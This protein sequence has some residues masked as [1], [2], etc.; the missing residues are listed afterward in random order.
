MSSIDTKLSNQSE[1][2]N[3]FSKESDK[4]LKEVEK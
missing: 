3:Q 1:A 4:L 2:L